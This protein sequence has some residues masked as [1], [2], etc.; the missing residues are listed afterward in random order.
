MTSSIMELVRR[1]HKVHRDVQSLWS[2]FLRYAAVA[3]PPEAESGGG[4]PKNP[5]VA[6]GAYFA[7][8]WPMFR[9]RCQ[10]S[11]REDIWR[12]APLRAAC[13]GPVQSPDQ[14]RNSDGHVPTNDGARGGPRLAHVGSNACRNYREISRRSPGVARSATDDPNR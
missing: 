3:T 4:N 9:C 6:T 13:E 10:Q 11:N 2:D 5:L 12:A 1:H 8:P 14:R 7:Q